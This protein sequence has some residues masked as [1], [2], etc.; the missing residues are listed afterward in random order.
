MSE[1]LNNQVEHPMRY[2]SEQYRELDPGEISARTAV[3]FDEARGVFTLTL[4]NS[5]YEIAYPD[6]SVRFIS[7][8]HD[9]ISDFSSGQILFLRYLVNGHYVRPRG[10]FLAYRDVPWG[11]VYIRNFT[12]RCIRRLAYTFAGKGEAVAR[13]M[14]ALDGK[15]YEKGDIGWEFEFM[16]GLSIRFSIWNADEEFPP[17][18]Q[19]LFSDNF[20]YAFDAEDMAYIGDIFIHILSAI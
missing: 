3:P 16:P 5:S 6:F 8:E 13:K 18:A 20:H 9:R 12:G 17:S 15:V 7:G 10:E 14:A 19:I 1:L 11:E 4:M 2:Y